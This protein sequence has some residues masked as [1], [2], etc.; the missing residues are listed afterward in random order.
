VDIPRSPL[1]GREDCASLP[2]YDRRMSRRFYTLDV[3][4]REPLAGNPLAVVIDCDGLDSSRMQRI[5]R[6]FNL[7][8]T[9]FVLPARNPINTARVK[10][11][12]PATELPFAGH[13]TVGTAV[14]LASLRAPELAGGRDLAVV[15]EEEVGDIH[16][17]V[18]LA[19]EAAS[20][21][22]F[23]LPRL[24]E[25]IGD[26]DARALA[27]ALSL[28][29]AD[30]GFDGHAPSVYSAGTPFCFAPIASRA[31]LVRAKPDPALI[32]RAAADGRGVYLYARDTLDPAHAVH[33]RMFG[34][35]VGISEDPA[36][37]A[38]AAAFAGVAMEFEKPGDGEHA[39]VIEQGF[40]MGRPSLITLGMHV[41]RGQL[42]GA[43]IGGHAVRVSEGSLAL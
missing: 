19:R 26:A 28:A 1:A 43:T 40:A 34:A 30:I 17:T 11:F 9:V 15:L 25:K 2:A 39:I 16:C 32:A 5:A 6:E 3:F 31:A 35:G 36:T 24:P 27:A 14:L 7:S 10:I 8:E 37:G 4:T 29:P 41:E 12:T 42:I 38:A 20:Y 22:Y 18:R 33:A 13:P 21:A 23:D